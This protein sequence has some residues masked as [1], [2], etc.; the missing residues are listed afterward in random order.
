MQIGLISDIH[1]LPYTTL[2]W[3]IQGGKTLAFLHVRPLG[4]GMEV[5]MKT[6]NTLSSAPLTV[7]LCDHKA[8]FWNNVALGSRRRKLKTCWP[9]LT[10]ALGTK[11][12]LGSHTAKGFSRVY[13]ALAKR[14][15][16]T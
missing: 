12:M 3:S 10:A 15:V 16:P 14:V 8:L 7:T 5:S 1:V 11:E 9:L 2:L 4:H 13:A 6:L